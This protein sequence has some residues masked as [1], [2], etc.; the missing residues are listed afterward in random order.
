MRKRAKQ[1]V[2]VRNPNLTGV[3][4]REEKE[5]M[6]KGNDDRDPAW[7][8]SRSDKKTSIHKFRKP[9]QNKQ[10]ETHIWLYH[11]TTAENER[12]KS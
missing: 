2:T 6:G 11:N 12:E 8:L 5:K 9:M 7:E 1:T 10:K 4:E 3:P